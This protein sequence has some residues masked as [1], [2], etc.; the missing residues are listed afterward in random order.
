[1]A[2]AD[3]KEVDISMGIT[4][5][6]S[7]PEMADANWLRVNDGVQQPIA[8]PDQERDWLFPGVDEHFRGIYT[9]AGLGYSSE[10]I[11]V[12]S[13]IAGEGKTTLSVGLGITLAQDFPDL[14]VLI[15]E[16]DVNS[17]VLAA[18]F[19]VQPNPGLVDCV[20]S[21]D[22]VLL[23]YRRTFLDN[24]QVVPVGGPLVGAGRVLRSIRMASAMEAMR[25]THDLVILDVPP[26]LVNSDSILITDLADCVICVVR[27]GVTPLD[28]VNKAISQLDAD[29]LRGVVLN[30]SDSA[31]PR[32]LRGLWAN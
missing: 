17:P 29:K 3:K 1:M 14:R 16:T 24:L 30:A 15:V 22:P 10:V 5:E 31:M 19:E 11:A 6:T 2:M 9:R 28:L 32:W 20:H 12:C 27:T 21:G 23:A 8:V 26:I 25:K 4:A 18:D 13:A 7:R